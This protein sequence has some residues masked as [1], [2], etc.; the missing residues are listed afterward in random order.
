M[1]SVLNIKKLKKITMKSYTVTKTTTE[2]TITIEHKGRSGE[3]VN[4]QWTD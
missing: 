3:R 4:S 1:F 2:L